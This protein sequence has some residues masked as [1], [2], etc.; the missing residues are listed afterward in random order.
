MFRSKRAMPMQTTPASVTSTAASTKP[1][2]PFIETLQ[3]HRLVR[4]K[5]DPQAAFRRT[6]RKRSKRRYGQ[7]HCRRDEP[8]GDRQQ[9]V[10]AKPR[11]LHAV[12]ADVDLSRCQPI[13]LSQRLQ[14]RLL[15]EGRI[16]A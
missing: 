4:L 3:L 11:A 13:D 16:K 9:R 15:V 2:M 8:H 10:A 12:L 6:S 1:A 14:N 7:L 5:P